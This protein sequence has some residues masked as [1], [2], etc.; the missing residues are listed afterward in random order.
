MDSYGVLAEYYD[1]LTTD[2]DYENWADFLEKLFARS[3]G[4]IRSVVDLGCGTAS[5]S[6]ERSTPVSSSVTGCST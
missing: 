1:S 6:A 5:M 4:E 2:V 3:G